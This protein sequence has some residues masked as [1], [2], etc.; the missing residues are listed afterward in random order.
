MITINP[1]MKILVEN[2]V[3]YSERNRLYSLMESEMNNVNNAMISNLYKSAVDKAHIDFDD[4]PQS[5]GDI[6]AYSGYNSMTSVLSLI[7][8][9]ATKANTRIA[10]IDVVTQAIS[11]IAAYRDLFEKGFKLE[12]EFIILQYN[13]LVYACV[14]AVSTIL[15]SYVDFIKR[16]DRVEFTIIK[17]ARQGGSLC[18]TNLDKFNLSVKQGDFA[19]VLNAVVNSGKE[20]F[21]G[22][23]DLIV[24]TLIIGGVVVLVP[25]IRELIFFF[26]YS[27]MKTADYLKQQA[28]LLEINKQSLESGTVSAKKKNEI[29]KKQQEAINKLNEISDRIKVNHGLTENKTAVALKQENKSWTLDN[30]QS[31]SASTDQNG[32]KLL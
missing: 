5:K 9:I 30:I 16:P 3:T 11:N 6:T 23:D 14:E 7:K 17:N 20:G 24:P 32:F 25:L 19:R 12:K 2:A 13:T 22:V 29:L 15:A 8:E 4:I 18:I 1:V 31:Q 27:R 28:R 21:V 26:Y 10:E